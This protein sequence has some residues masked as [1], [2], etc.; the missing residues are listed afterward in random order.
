MGLGPI[1]ACGKVTSPDDGWDLG[2]LPCPFEGVDKGTP[3]LRS[4]QDFSRH[5]LPILFTEGDFRHFCKIGGG[6]PGSC[7]NRSG[8]GGPLGNGFDKCQ[9]LATSLPNDSRWERFRGTTAAGNLIAAGQQST[10][11]WE[12]QRPVPNGGCSEGVP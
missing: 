3:S 2:A 10:R 4:R 5:F 9:P 11:G 12:S 6:A 8:D 7:V 1:G